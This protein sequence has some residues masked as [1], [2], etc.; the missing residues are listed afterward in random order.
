M[1]AN[2][3]FERRGSGPVD[4]LSLSFFDAEEAKTSRSKYLSRQMDA[5]SATS[6]LNG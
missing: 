5:I 1:W 2:A 4:F 3:L 6:P